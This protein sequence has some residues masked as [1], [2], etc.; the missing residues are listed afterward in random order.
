MGNVALVGGTG[1]GEA[2][3][4]IDAAPRSRLGAALA[5]L[6]GLCLSAAMP[7]LEIA[8]LAWIGLVPLLF[9]LRGRSVRAAFGLGWITG[10]VF[11][12]V[13]CY[14]IIHTIGHYTELPTALAAMVL[15]LMS[16]VLGCYAGAFAAGVRWFEQRGLPVAWLAPPLWVTLE[17]LRGWFF[18]G[19]PWAA[20][21]YTQYRFH[22]LAQMAEVTGVYGISAVLVLFNVVVA[23]VLM[24]RGPGARRQLP[25]LA[26]LTL[27][28][29]ALVGLGRWRAASLAAMPPAGR[30]RVA[31]TQGNV[32]QDVKWDPAFVE[33]TMRRYRTLTLDAARERPDL[34][35]WPETATPFFFQEP[36]VRRDEL[37][38]LVREVGAPLLFGTPAFRRGAT[39]V[40]EQL[41]RAY[42]L[43][44]DGSEAGFYDKIELVPFGE[45]VPFQSVFF[46]V[47]Q[48]VTAVGN[49]G[50]GQVP[51]VFD[52][53]GGRFGTLICYEG[54][55]PGLTRRFVADGADFLVNITNDAWFGRTSA[56]HQHLA[57]DTFRAIENRVPF[58]RAANTGISAV[59]DA[60]GRI[61]W[62]G[63]LFEMLWHVDE[64]TWSGVRTFY[65]R[66]GDVFVWACVLATL[67]GLLLG[68]RAR[69]R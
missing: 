69:A 4:V 6:S 61:R 57:Q 31:L 18:I 48:M 53:G 56:P 30:L 19:F 63:P 52:L 20:L 13:T 50:A 33:E 34:V 49:I 12:L 41:N 54:I 16:S 42:L 29:I 68:L 62:Q 25:A 23:A 17:W 28:L 24:S 44:P 60:D 37:L 2:V 35:V 64:I 10:T 32:A 43:E 38:A 15:L 67:A 39:G 51:T 5:A 7:S 36:G 46:F 1:A 8:A 66:H 21:G 14:W 55:F 59:I 58:V 9:A 65:T 45:Y 26:T 22:S 11:F 27:V 3:A 47:E 40:L